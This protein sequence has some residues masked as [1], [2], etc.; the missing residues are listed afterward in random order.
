MSVNGK[1]YPCERIGNDFKFGIIENGKVKIYYDDI[2]ESYNQ[3]FKRFAKI[4]GNC[5]AIE[6]CSVCAVSDTTGYEVCERSK[7]K[8]ISEIISFFEAK[9]QTLKKIIK[10]ITL[11]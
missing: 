4:C 5:K 8:N 2:L 10:E 6:F 9:P 3:L 7:P 11:I 1:I